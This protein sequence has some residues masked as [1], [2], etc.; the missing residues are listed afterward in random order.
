MGKIL[1][2]TSDFLK[3]SNSFTSARSSDSVDSPHHKE[4]GHNRAMDRLTRY[5]I[6]GYVE[7]RVPLFEFEGI[8]TYTL[9]L[10]RKQSKRQSK[11]ASIFM[12]Y[13]SP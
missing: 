13:F 4:V 7:V 10:Y 9:Y 2:K 11:M 6:L 5:L 12:H 8:I 3:N 1:P